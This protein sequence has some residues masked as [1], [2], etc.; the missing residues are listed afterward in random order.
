MSRRAKIWLI[1]SAIV[2]VFVIVVWFVGAALHLASPDI[3]VFRAGLWVLGAVAAGFVVW[4]LLRQLAPQTAPGTRTD[5]IDAAMNAARAQLA[6]AR[7]GGKGAGSLA[8]SRMVILLGAEGSA[9]TTTIVRSGLEPELMA[10]GVSRDDTVAPTKGVNVWYARDTVFVEAGGPL[11]ADPGR[12]A[13]LIRHVQPRRLAAVFGGGAQAPRLAMVCVSCDHLVQPGASE[14]AVALGRMLRDRLSELSR[15]LGIRLPVYVLFTKADRIAYFAD[16][17][18]NFSNDEA[19]EVV[20]VT[21]PADVGAVGLYADRQSKRI[22]DSFQR[23]FV[24]LADKRLQVLGRE[25]AVEPKPGAY[26][27]PRELRKTGGVITQ[28]LVELCRPSQLQVSPFLRGYYFA[29][30]RPVFIND[31]APAAAAAAMQSRGEARSATAVFR[32][33]LM[34]AQTR[35]VAPAAA[36]RKVPQWVFLGRLFTDV[37][38]GDRAAMNVTRGGARV[39]TLRRV[40]LGLA[41]AAGVVLALGFTV[42]WSGNRKL[43]G[44]TAAETRA[45][46]GL[47]PT[48]TS[49]PPV[50][51][52]H[53]LDTLRTQLQMLRDY[54]RNGAP[55]RLRW[56]LYTGGALL[57][58]ARRAYFASYDKLLFEDTRGALVSALRAVPPAPRPTDDY[59]S[60]YRVLKAYLITTTN[61]ERSTEDFLAPVLL[62]QWTGVRAPDTAQSLLAQRQFAFYARELPLGDP[63]SVPAD[64]ALVGRARSF[65]RQFTGIEPIY[66]AMLAE[67]DSGHAAIQFNKMVPGS[68]AYVVDRVTVR[69]AFTK[70]GYTAMQ[71]ALGSADRFFQGERWVL[72]DEPPSQVDKT[73][74]LADL[75]ARYESD[76]IAAWRDYLQGAS[77]TRY[78][79]VSDAAAKL[80]QLS[81]NQS[82]L[83][84]LISIASQNTNADT[85]IGNAFQPAHV[86]VPPGQTDK[87]I[88]QS[89]QAYMSALLTL[90]GSLG[91]VATAPPGQSEGAIANATQ[92]ANAARGE[93]QKLAQGFVVG[94]EPT[95]ATAVQRLLTEPLASIDPYLRN[96]GAGQLNGKGQSFC[97][98]TAALFAK[99]PFNDHSPIQAS[100]DEVAA[101][102]KPGTGS[103]WTYYNDAL[104]NVLQAQGSTFAPK[105]GGTLS[106]NPEFLSFFNRAVQF[107]AAMFPAGS[108]EARLTLNLTNYLM[109]Q[110]GRL[111]VVGD[112]LTVDYAAAVKPHQFTW[113]FQPSSEAT[114]AVEQ[115][116]NIW[117]NV[118]SFHGTWAVFQLFGA[119]ASWEPTATDYRAEWSI[120]GNTAGA[121][122]G[123]DVG[124][125]NVPPVLRRGFFSGFS[126]VS[127]VVQ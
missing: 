14:Q 39:N 104:Q 46:M 6:A 119:A 100:L 59:G 112:G 20:G 69:G 115:G 81:G 49:A 60:T 73:K 120:P 28:F 13:R 18:R 74:A 37:V 25:A 56:G 75:R 98:K 42:S 16:Y 36:T 66:Q 87:L 71:K 23:L 88:G 91:Q 94:R 7:A 38:L 22:A 51:A 68:A 82:P 11:A 50:E 2:L 3:W 57:P 109:P 114:I 126:C 55:A 121:K 32:A 110:S 61:P 97:A 44:D 103:L 5:D 89:V 117:T 77:V 63:F 12:F 105:S 127:R 33:E 113:T 123:L 80:A 34:A 101:V 86:V 122:V 26:E 99:Y 96:Y 116:N 40:A 24:S 15:G 30:V 52:L 54:E 45:A 53:R 90:Q 47:A 125:N 17:V 1:A 41:T 76:Y 31:A 102:F 10:G 67:A 118:A 108:N 79:N 65:L 106:V 92:N 35:A 70:P 95:V 9:K 93:A 43:A 58:D 85:A 48:G 19:R 27:F 8:R 62:T 83:L 107:S 64:S 72:G 21:L 4:Y 29:G 124:L 84:S 111:R 78:G